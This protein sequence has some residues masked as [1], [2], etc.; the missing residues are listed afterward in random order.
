[1]YSRLSCLRII[2]DVTKD[3]GEKK[4]DL[5]P[6]SRKKIQYKKNEALFM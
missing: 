3:E 4:R 1:V 6:N 2:R 5:A